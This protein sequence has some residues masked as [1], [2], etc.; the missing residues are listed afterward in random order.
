M[1]RTRKPEPYTTFERRTKSLVTLYLTRSAFRLARFV[2]CENKKVAAF[3]YTERFAPLAKVLFE[4]LLAVASAKR[5]EPH[6]MG[7]HNA[8][9]HGDL[10]E[11]VYMPLPP[12]FH[13][14]HPKSVV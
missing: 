12:G 7:V 1:T 6:Q 13:A 3:Y 11:E 4:P 2:V 5:W 14:S 8:F 9:L 10:Q